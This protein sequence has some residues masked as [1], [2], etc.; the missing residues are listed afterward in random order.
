MPATTLAAGG[1]A[2]LAAFEVRTLQ[3]PALTKRRRALKIAVMSGPLDTGAAKRTSLDERLSKVEHDLMQTA[4]RLY[5]LEAF[6]EELDRVTG[7]KPF[8]IWNDIV[9][10]MLLDSRDML[11]IYLASWT[12]HLVEAGG[13]FAE[14]KANHLPDLP[15]KRRPTNR[16][17]NDAHLRS[18]LDGY[19]QAAVSRL[20]PEL[21]AETATP[22]ALD[23]LVRRVRQ[24][25]DG[26]RNDRNQNR[27]HAFERGK[28]ATAK[29]LDFMELRQ[30]VREAE[31]LIND[32][33]LVGCASTLSYHDM[34]DA[35]GKATAAEL[36]DSVLI[37]HES[38]QDLVMAGKDR[39]AYYRWLH[40]QHD[41]GGDLSAALFND[42]WE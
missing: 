26:L 16:T 8:R 7:R 23:D 30:H 15:A 32:I 20:F 17:D 2:R 1:Y 19:H 24:S 29:M 38:R 10:M 37:G 18:L 3:A 4:R 40:E 41:K 39:D 42:F 25:S 13:L 36:A 9:W 5:A 11:V 34:N 22:A 14:L 35:D 27:A 21:A 6:V 28:P 33:R 12:K 31:E